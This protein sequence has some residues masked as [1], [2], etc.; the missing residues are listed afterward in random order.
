MTP[1]EALI[2]CYYACVDTGDIDGLVKLFQPD[3]EY[4]RPGYPVMIGHAE[5][6]AFYR[7]GRK[8][9]GGSH[10]LT[11]VLDTGDRVAVHG[12]FT[13]EL[14]DGTGMR[15]RFADFFEVGDDGRFTR[16]DTYYFA[17]LG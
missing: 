13:G 14:H 10:A 8:F 1:G 12:E 9:R 6:A 15:L 2:R 3:A 4:C 7:S 16:R 11:A 17:P 5:M